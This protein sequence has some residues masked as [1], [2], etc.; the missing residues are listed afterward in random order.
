MLPAK[1][2]SVTERNVMTMRLMTTVIALLAG[3]LLCQ[4]TVK[5]EEIKVEGGAAAISVVFSP[6]KEAFEKATGDTLTIVLS[7]PTKA[8]MSLENGAID[9]AALNTLFLDYGIEQAKK[10]GVAIDP[11]TLKTI[12]LAKSKLVVFLHKSNTV[13]QLTQK[14]LQDI[15]SGKV[16]NWRDVGGNDQDIIVVWGKETPILNRLFSKEIMAGIPVTPKAMPAGD[17][18]NLRAIVLATPGAIAINTNGLMLP[19]LKVPDVPEMQLPLIAV[20]KGPPS[21]K[22]SRLLKFYQEEF[23]YMHD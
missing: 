4:D 7:N 10:Q 19:I 14:Q 20:T 17:H 21:A 6:I 8:L 9:L 3:I 22:V 11:S 13:Q 1:C 2:E 23:G 12:E 5:A 18:F 15:F 16:T